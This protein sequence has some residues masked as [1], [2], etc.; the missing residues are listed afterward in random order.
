MEGEPTPE[1]DNWSQ[2]CRRLRM[3]PSAAPGWKMLVAK[4]EHA[5]WTY[6]VSM[7]LAVLL[8][9]VL[10]FGGFDRPTYHT[11]V[12]ALVLMT[13]LL[14]SASGLYRFGP[15]FAATAIGRTGAGV[16]MLAVCSLSI[17]CFLGP[18]SYVPFNSRA[19]TS[20]LLLSAIFFVCLSGEAGGNPG[21][22]PDVP[23]STLK[24]P[25]LRAG[26]EAVRGLNSIS[27]FSVA[28]SMFIKVRCALYVLYVR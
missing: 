1:D 9:A 12:P 19:T 15:T 24:Q 23:H 6:F 5:M 7:V 14:A 20:V 28:R 16:I 11:A 27:D 10:F 21:K 18:P 26:S 22:V 8:F 13:S 25:I 4:P 17:M 3:H 2:L